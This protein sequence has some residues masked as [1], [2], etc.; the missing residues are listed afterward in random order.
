MSILRRPIVIP[1]PWRF[2]RRHRSS[3]NRLKRVGLE[4]APCLTPLWIENGFVTRLFRTRLDR[5]VLYRLFSISIVWASI[6]SSMRS[7]NSWSLSTLSKAFLMSISQICVL[8]PLLACICAISS[9]VSICSVQLRPFLNPA[10]SSDSLLCTSRC[11]EISWLSNLS[12][13]FAHRFSMIW[14]CGSMGHL[15]LS[16][17]WEVGRYGPG[18]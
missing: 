7:E 15:V 17:L 16:G 9:R 11:L 1:F 4:H 10:C 18:S 2:I 14:V 6:P 8:Y 3:G 12:S 5:S 13:I